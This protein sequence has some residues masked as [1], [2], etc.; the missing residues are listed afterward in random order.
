MDTV[1]T[2]DCC[3]NETTEALTLY[4]ADYG[5]GGQSDEMCC[6]ACMEETAR[7]EAEI[8]DD[9]WRIKEDG[10]WDC[11]CVC[12]E[13][14]GAQCSGFCDPRKGH[15]CMCEKCGEKEESESETE[16]GECHTSTHGRKIRGLWN[17]TLCEKCGDKE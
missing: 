2:C 14:N 1:L 16:C 4:K 5:Q 15:H 7:L 10:T 3:G 9:T 13:M 8:A 17:N 12:G 11:V 6:R